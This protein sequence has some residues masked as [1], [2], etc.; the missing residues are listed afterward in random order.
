M[1]LWI[2]FPAMITLNVL[3]KASPYIILGGIESIAGKTF[4]YKL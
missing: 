3:L 4:E 2:V 1:I